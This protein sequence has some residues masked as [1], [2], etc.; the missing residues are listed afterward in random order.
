[1][2][3]SDDIR[4]WVGSLLFHVLIAGLLFLWQVNVTTGE[5]EYLEVSWGT[6]APV[7]VSVPSTPALPGSDAGPA[8]PSYS[9]PRTVDLPER[10]FPSNDDDVVRVPSGRKMDVPGAPARSRETIAGTVR[11][12]KDRGVGSGMGSKERFA[13][14][15]RGMYAAAVA[16]PRAGGTA[17]SGAGNG[18]SMSMTWS[19][20]GTRKKISG[21]LPE[22]P[23]GV[24]VETQ[25]RIETVVLPDGTV[26]SLKPAL[27]GNT[28]LEDAAM[29]AVRLWR[30][31]PLR[32]SSPQREQ[33]CSIVFNFRLR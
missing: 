23:A 14:P 9:T 6:V 30:F 3:S 29:N 12:Q 25:I 2:R 19:D 22:Y 16:D 24:N 1:M 28:K 13:T 15:G 4:G 5:P 33:V 18:V 10:K 17:G 26:R 20:G 7:A 8:S 21:E 32:R 11:A 31:E 27:K